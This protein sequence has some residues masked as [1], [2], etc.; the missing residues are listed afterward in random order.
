MCFPLA[1]YTCLWAGWGQPPLPDRL[2][3]CSTFLSLFNH[4]TF[5]P[6]QNYKCWRAET[7]PGVLTQ[8]LRVPTPPPTSRWVT[9]EGGVGW[10]GG[11]SQ[12]KRPGGRFQ[13]RPRC[14]KSLARTPSGLGLQ[15]PA[16]KLRKSTG[17]TR[18]SRWLLGCPLNGS[19]RVIPKHFSC[20][21]SKTMGWLLTELGVWRKAGDFSYSKC[22]K[23]VERGFTP[24]SE[25]LSLASCG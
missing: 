10:W 15:G 16:G 2:V 20:L 18:H 4:F 17:R 25:G 13:H 11:G 19:D 14:R 22:I 1:P 8:C 7:R 21:T 23:T 12:G 9:A 5:C 3:S 6:S 24:G